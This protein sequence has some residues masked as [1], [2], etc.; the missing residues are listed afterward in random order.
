MITT[1]QTND[2]KEI[3][4]EIENGVTEIFES[5]KY[6]L[7]LETLS[8]F[9][10]YS[11]NNL[12]L[13]L[14]QY[15]EACL[16]AG[17]KK[18]QNDF[19]RS[20]KKGEK[21]IKIIAPLVYKDKDKVNEENIVKGFKVISVFDYSQTAGEDLNPIIPK[22]LNG[23]VENYSEIIEILK[24]FSPFEISYDKLPN[25]TNGYCNCKDKKIVI[26]DNLSEQQNIKT[27]LHEISH[28]ILH[29][30]VDKKNIETA[31][32]QAESI[33]YTVC[34]Y[35][36]LD[37]SDFSFSYIARWCKNKEL[38]ELKDSLNIINDTAKEFIKY[39]ENYININKNK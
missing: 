32:I 9:S 7:Y 16:I 15:P 22:L 37:A 1:I 31:E 6:K 34:R 19:K 25:D 2:V 20:V 21:G 33:A 29:K 17:F 38:K 39:I 3:L 11:L 10:N 23:E 5:E 24:K 26:S 4:K 36:N 13:I 12:F 14:K 8:K 35:L 27:I 18:W 30:K 28:A